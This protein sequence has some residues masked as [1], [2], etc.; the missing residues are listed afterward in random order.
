MELQGQTRCG[1]HIRKLNCPK[2][3]E[4]AKIRS[5]HFHTSADIRLATDYDPDIERRWQSKSRWIVSR[6]RHSSRD[7]FIAKSLTM[8]VLSTVIE[9][10]TTAS[11]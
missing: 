11:P 10:S 9:E 8:P 7:G 5:R 2:Q 1:C 4:F 6:M 3:V